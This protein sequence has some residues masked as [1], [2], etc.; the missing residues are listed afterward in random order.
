MKKIYFITILFIIGFFCAYGQQIPV[1]GIVSIKNSR[2]F[3]GKV[4]YIKNVEVS[5]EKV[6]S[7]LT[8]DDGRFTLQI[9]GLPANTQ[10]T[11]SVKPTD[12]YKGYKVVNLKELQ[13][14]TLGRLSPVEVFLC[15]PEELEK[16]L[17]E[18]VGINMKK[19]EQRVEKEKKKKR[20][21]IELDNLKSQNLYLSDRYKE[22]NDSLQLITE[23]IDKAYERV[24]KYAELLVYE[25]LDNKDEEY[26]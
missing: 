23:D 3:T 5:H 14:I 21:S 6:K 8:D 9:A 4:K 16:L 18:M 26:V 15:Q 11:I 25:N 13:N 24:R 20:L 22:L 7:D 17:M 1:K 19:Y 2:T 12:P 10:T